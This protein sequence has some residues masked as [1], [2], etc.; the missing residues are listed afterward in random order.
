MIRVVSNILR[1]S[2]SNIFLLCYLGILVQAFFQ[3]VILKCLNTSQLH[4]YWKIASAEHVIL[5]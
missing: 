5:S 3:N 2:G 1:G 4:D